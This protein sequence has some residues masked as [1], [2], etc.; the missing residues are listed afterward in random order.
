M[1]ALFND[2]ALGLVGGWRGGPAQVC[3]LSSAL[4]GT[5]SGSGVANVVASRP[6]HH[7][8]DEALRLPLGLRR[9]RR[10]D[11]VDGRPDHAAGD[12]RGR[13]HH[14]RDA[15]RALCRRSSRRRSSR[16]MLYFGACFWQ[17]H[18][19]AGK[20][21]LARHGPRRAAEPVGGGARALAAGAAARGARLPAVRRLH[22]DLRRHDGA[23]ADR[24]AD[25]RHA[26][27]GADR[28]A[29]LP[30]RV[31]DRARARRGGLPALRRRTSWRW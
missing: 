21:G 24:R 15:E 16:R 27:R 2:V 3:V 11:L 29:R 17:V 8:A 4:M 22:A 25:P 20:A 9:R 13:L 5:I 19:E 6:V 30:R 7:P 31:L 14:G 1:I 28:A 18:L 26:A 10:G 23:G 12:G